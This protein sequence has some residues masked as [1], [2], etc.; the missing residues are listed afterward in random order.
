VCTRNF[1]TFISNKM[2]KYVF[3]SLKIYNYSTSHHND[4]VKLIQYILMCLLISQ[5]HQ[6]RGLYF[7]NFSHCNVWSK[8]Y[9]F[10]IKLSVQPSIYTCLHT[11]FFIFFFRPIHV[12]L[13]IFVFSLLI[14]LSVCLGRSWVPRYLCF[15]S[16]GVSLMALVLRP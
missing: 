4:E 16:L 2:S 6:K 13:F 7:H 5:H 11:P 1:K 8:Y 12:L 9:I 14:C 10:Y 15:K 3:I